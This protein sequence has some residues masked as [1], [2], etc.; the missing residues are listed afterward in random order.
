MISPEQVAFLPYHSV[1]SHVFTFTQ[2]LRSRA[3]H[4]EATRTLFVDL[5]KAYNRVSLASLW[6]L[7]R[8]MGVPDTIVELL[9]DW[10][11]KRRTRL[12]VNGELSDWYPM[13]A[14][15]PQGDP[16]SCLL[17]NLYVEPL[18]RYIKSRADIRVKGVANPGTHQIINAFFSQ[19]TQRPSLASSQTTR[20]NRWSQ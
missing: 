15:T 12:R 17:F 1:E 4:G 18:I 3:R 16:L 11:S 5:S 10:A 7:L 19:M 6:F 13:L 14:G 20:R 8:Q 2:L 9:D